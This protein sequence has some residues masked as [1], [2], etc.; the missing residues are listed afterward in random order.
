MT[1]EETNE[2]VEQ[3]AEPI[4]EHIVNT[5]TEAAQVEEVV[6]E[7]VA[8][9]VAEPV[10]EIVAEPVAEV[11]SEP[12]V[13]IVTEAVAEPVA[14]TVAEPVTATPEK[15]SRRTPV[16]PV[17]LADFDWMPLERN[18]KSIPVMNAKSWKRRMTK[19]CAPSRIMK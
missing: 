17:S 16:A 7:T 13:E 10:A 9:I 11:V 6:A 15:K 2:N 19:P 12:V 8:E 1:P 4:V 3:N 18:M 5:E 14:E